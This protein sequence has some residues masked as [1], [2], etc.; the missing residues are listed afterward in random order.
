MRAL[1]AFFGLVLLEGLLCLLDEGQH[2][3]H[4]EDAAGHAIGV[5]QLELVELLAD[6]GERDRLADDLLDRQRGTAACVAVELGEDDAVEAELVVE[7]LGDGDRVLAGHG[8]DDEEDVVGVDRL[9]DL[10]DLLHQLLVDG[11]TA[12]GV[13]DDDVAAGRPGLG[14]GLARRR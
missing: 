4:A 7:G 12:G 8:V 5:E 11:Q 13:D 3:A 2:V 9:G 10:T 14:D 6:R 1:A